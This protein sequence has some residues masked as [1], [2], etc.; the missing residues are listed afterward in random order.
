MMHGT[1]LFYLS[2]IHSCACQGACPPSP[3][4]L[5]RYCNLVPHCIPIPCHMHGSREHIICYKVRSVCPVI[6]THH[7]FKHFTIF[8]RNIFSAIC[9]IQQ[10]VLGEMGWHL[11]NM[12]SIG[13][14]HLQLQQHISKSIIQP[15]LSQIEITMMYS[16][17]TWNKSVSSIYPTMNFWIRN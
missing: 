7:I 1:H 13:N 14:S 2:I 5:A 10:N 12:V 8:Q 11:W 15:T 3:A 17:N 9:V 4:L 6:A 16:K